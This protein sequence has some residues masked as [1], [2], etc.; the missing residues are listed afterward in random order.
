MKRFIWILVLALPLQAPALEP[1]S[2][3]ALNDLGRILNA[4]P[5][6]REKLG[7]KPTCRMANPKA[8][9]VT[10][11]SPDCP[12]ARLILPRLKGMQI[13]L[14][15]RG[16][17]FVFVYANLG[18]AK[19]ERE[20]LAIAQGRNP[21][22]GLDRL[23]E[24]G[25]DGALPVTVLLDDK[26]L[27]ADLLEARV[28]SETFLLDANYEVKYRGRIDDQYGVGQRKPEVGK[29][30]LA[31][32]IEAVL[33]GKAVPDFGPNSKAQGCIIERPELTFSK[34]IAPLLNTNCF[35]CHRE[36][37]IQAHVLLS[38]YEDV[39][40]VLTTL[41][42]RVQ[43]RIMPPWS[44]H[45]GIG[46]F[47]N[48][49]ALSDR[50][51]LDI[52]RWVREG[53]EEGHRADLPTPP[54]KIAPDEFTLAKKLGRAPDDV[55]IMESAVDVEPAGTMPYMYRDAV[56]ETKAGA[57]VRYEKV[58]VTEDRWLEA[59]EILPGAP[60][61]VHHINVYVSRPV[62]NDEWFIEPNS[63]VTGAGKGLVDLV[64]KKRFKVDPKT[65]KFASHIYGVNGFKQMSYLGVYVPGVATI[66]LP[67]GYR[68]KVPKGSQLVFEV[69]Y[70]P[71][72]NATSDRSKIGVW[73][74]KET[75]KHELKTMAF[76]RAVDLEIPA[77]QVKILTQEF[78]FP[79]KAAIAIL[80][81]H[82]HYRARSFVYEVFYPQD[83][84]TAVPLLYIP[85]YDFNNQPYYTLKQPLVV[86]A[87]TKVRIRGEYDNTT[88]NPN[89]TE[90]MAAKTVYF[91]VQSHEEMFWG[92]LNFSYLE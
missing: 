36:G 1:A 16:V 27:I 73:W 84:K 43:D 41:K 66:N 24:T 50:D 4:T 61:V 25:E 65:M 45:P 60:E 63:L 89:V 88:A 38:N 28:L 26:Q 59:S 67:T 8:T 49:A 55:F 75:P 14:A 68:I 47:A 53:A 15:E 23:E 82:G 18:I 76:G 80:R 9:V 46:E 6:V 56:R 3:K 31:D 77:N 54:A 34:N 64:G 5:D 79:R 20:V 83:P 19:R 12:L 35:S 62:G 91:G 37:G 39:R 51:R 10:F 92:F 86:P 57:E 21:K 69:H 85:K 40:N 11:M 30:F 33:A 87:G 81:P 2:V 78:V 22:D 7:V 71:N 17:Q 32:A 70:T 90:E 72:G 44:A 74:T 48:S 42:E 29:H 13:A 58:E 52:L